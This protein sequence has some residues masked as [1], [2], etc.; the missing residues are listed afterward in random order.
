MSARENTQMRH[1]YIQHAIGAHISSLVD[2]PVS[3]RESTLTEQQRQKRREAQARREYR[4]QTGQS[5]QGSLK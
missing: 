3:K 5:W 1:D 2:K 4:E